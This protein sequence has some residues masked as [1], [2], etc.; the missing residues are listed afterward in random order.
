MERQRFT[1]NYFKKLIPF[2]I[3]G[4]I[5]GG[6]VYSHDSKFFSLI[7]NSISQGKLLTDIN[8]LLESLRPIPQKPIDKLEP[9]SQEELIDA[10][11]GADLFPSVLANASVFDLE[12]TQ[13]DYTGNKIENVKLLVILNPIDNVS[14]QHTIRD[15]NGSVDWQEMYEQAG[16]SF[17]SL[18][19]G[20]FE[21]DRNKTLTLSS[22]INGVEVGLI[23]KTNYS[24][25]VVLDNN[26]HLL[27]VTDIE[28]Q[29]LRKDNANLTAFEYPYVIYP[30][31]LKEIQDPHLKTSR[32]TEVWKLIENNVMVTFYDKNNQAFTFNLTTTRKDKNLTTTGTGMPVY[33]I[34]ELV[35]MLA[36]S[37]IPE[38]GTWVIG[39]A[40]IS[41]QAGT[42]V[43][44]DFFR[45][46]SSVY[47]ED[48][49]IRDIVD[50]E[51]DNNLL[52]RTLVGNGT[53]VDGATHPEYSLVMSLEN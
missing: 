38:G 35:N 5:L 37:I 14:I 6:V 17:I 39:I 48:A 49:F 12:A 28:L 1:K 16:Y 29:E 51:S 26:G 2:A 7:A 11:I 15:D 50:A 23:P 8:E 44:P 46:P 45:T 27:V 25:G 3:A 40:D 42:V 20:P 18:P 21:P 32:G 33:A 13:L 34:T 36:K 31:N 30:E 41:V 53:Y 19:S 22:Q 9:I 24:G 10:G 4:S 47:K 43:D 52:T